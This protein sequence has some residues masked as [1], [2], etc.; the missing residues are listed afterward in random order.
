MH[1]LLNKDFQKNNWYSLIFYLKLIIIFQNNLLKLSIGDKIK[2]YL[3]LIKLFFR[4]KIVLH[5]KF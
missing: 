5:E 3:K 2:N 4:I 1:F